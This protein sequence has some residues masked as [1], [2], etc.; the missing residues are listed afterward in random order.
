AVVMPTGSGMASAGHVEV[1]FQFTCLM[2]PGRY[3][4]HCGAMAGSDGEE[5][6]VHRLVDAF[7][8]DVIHPS[9]KN[10]GGVLPQGLVDLDFAGRVVAHAE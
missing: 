2:Y 5:H 6:Y 1:E 9:R 4:I 3:F 7:E 10:R 8:I